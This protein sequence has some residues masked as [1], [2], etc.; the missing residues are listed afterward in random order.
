MQE[1]RASAPQLG[2]Q[3]VIDE[4]RGKA[5]GSDAIRSP[6]NLAHPSTNGYNIANKMGVQST[7]AQGLCLSARVLTDRSYGATP[8]AG[9]VEPRS[10]PDPLLKPPFPR[11]PL[12]SPLLQ[13][14]A[15]QG[16]L[17][18]SYKDATLPRFLDLEQ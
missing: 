2:E 18:F 8:K 3:S 15:D 4:E 5:L 12:R 11:L 17:T 16:L 7:Q 9:S 10:G 14:L 13:Q 6:H 1:T